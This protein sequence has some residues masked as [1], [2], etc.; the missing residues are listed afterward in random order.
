MIE[1]IYC[2]IDEA[3]LKMLPGIDSLKEWELVLDDLI[4]RWV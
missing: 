1:T 3:G 2:S 4:A